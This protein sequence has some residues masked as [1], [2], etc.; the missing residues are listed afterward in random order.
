VGTVFHV[1]AVFPFFVWELALGLWLTFK[2]FNES[3]PI[4][5]AERARLAPATGLTAKAGAA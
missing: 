5:V 2:G 4:A 3:A 1:V